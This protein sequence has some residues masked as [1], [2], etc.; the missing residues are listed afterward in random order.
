MIN[1]KKKKVVKSN[2]NDD[3][4]WEEV[5][6]GGKRMKLVNNMNGFKLTPIGDIFRG[7]LKIETETK[8]NSVSKSQLEPF[9]VLSLD[10]PPGKVQYD[11]INNLL[12]NYFS[13]RQ[14]D[15]DDI[16]AKLYQ[17]LYIEKPPSILIIHLKTFYFDP[18]FQTINKV[19]RSLVYEESI[20]LAKDYI[21][22]GNKSKYGD[23]KYELFSIIIHKGKK[24][25][26]GHYT[27]YCKDDKAAWWSIDD[28][29]IYK[30]D[31]NDIFK[32]RPYLLFY[33]MGSS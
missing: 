22:P 20:T 2:E 16:N 12:K 30:C 29:S 6:K 3:G 7:T 10:V 32:V 28:S 24:A 15:T 18:N 19:M 13:R 21:S 1:L 25:S 11:E 8:G 33:R 14:I 17:R 23:V 9:F 27:C 4:E 31:K 26:E 5:K